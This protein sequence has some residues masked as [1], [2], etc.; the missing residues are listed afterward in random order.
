MKGLWVIDS[1]FF[2]DERGTLVKPFEYHQYFA[3]GLQCNYE[4][5]FYSVSRKG[6]IR[7][8]H[9]Q[10]PPMTSEKL[11][12][13]SQGMIL[14][15]VLDLRVQSESYQQIF[16]IELSAENH[17]AIYLPQG[18]AHAFCVLSDKATVYYQISKAHSPEKDSGIKWNS[19]NFDWPVENP[20]VSKR[21]NEL[22][23]LKSFKSP[24]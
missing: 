2:A 22:T 20:I 11:V 9:F 5:T 4:E 14:D 3:R 23:D 7:G 13:V 17:K 6:V 19:V 15:V 16:S 1:H 24:F 18:L 12:W 10:L 21:D 8:F